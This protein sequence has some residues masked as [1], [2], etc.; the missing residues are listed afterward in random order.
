VEEKP[1]L[2]KADAVDAHPSAHTDGLATDAA[3]TYL[4]KAESHSFP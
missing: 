3:S 1:V 2:G 4:F